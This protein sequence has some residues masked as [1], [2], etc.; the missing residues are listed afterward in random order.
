MILSDYFLPDS[1]DPVLTDIGV[2]VVLTSTT[3]KPLSK[4]N[5]PPLDA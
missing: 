2:G 3:A 5:V 4:M 1:N